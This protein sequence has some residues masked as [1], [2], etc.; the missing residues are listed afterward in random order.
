MISEGA[1]DTVDWESQFS[2]AIK[3][4]NYFLKYI[5]NG[6]QLLEIEIWLFYCIVDQINA[7][8]II[9]VLLKINIF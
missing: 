1:C 8:L 4:I 3:E 2:F 7:A 5:Q 9:K 6:R